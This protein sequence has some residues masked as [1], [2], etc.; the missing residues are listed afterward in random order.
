MHVICVNVLSPVPAVKTF[1]IKITLNLSPAFLV[2]VTSISIW[3]KKT[4]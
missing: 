3:L 1:R 4:D 2:L